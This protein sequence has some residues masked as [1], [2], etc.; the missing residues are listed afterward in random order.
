MT[1][2]NRLITPENNN[3]YILTQ[4]LFLIS[5]MDNG[6]YYYLYTKKEVDKIISLY[7]NKGFL[8]TDINKET[9]LEFESSKLCN[10]LLEENLENLICD[11]HIFDKKSNK[12]NLI[13]LPS[14]IS[15]LILTKEFEN[16]PSYNNCIDIE[17]NLELN[18]ILSSIKK[19]KFIK[20]DMIKNIAKVNYNSVLCFSR[21]YD[22]LVILEVNPSSIPL[23]H[24]PV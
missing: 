24:H 1:D 14:E 13:K 19:E 4:D 2:T 22:R 12:K 11:D 16:I 6:Y 18:F 8:F 17:N 21:E 3:L 9:N 10:I 5:K 7:L 23:F 15:K 20:N